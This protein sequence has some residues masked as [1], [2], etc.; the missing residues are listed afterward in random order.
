N[1]SRHAARALV[2]DNS[3]GG[4][5]YVAAV[6]RALKVHLV[7]TCIR[8]FSRMGEVGANAYYGKHSAT[9]RDQRAVATERGASVKHMDAR[10]SVRLIQTRDRIT[11]DRLRRIVLGCNHYRDSSIVAPVQRRVVG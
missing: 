11:L 6:V 8:E 1:V 4:Q 5:G 3:R 10:L 2:R 7:Y 9:S